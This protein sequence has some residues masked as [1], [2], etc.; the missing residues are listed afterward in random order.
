ML[1][2]HFD[3]D[4]VES[5]PATPVEDLRAETLGS[6]ATPLGSPRLR[7]L[8]ADAVARAAPA[9]ARAVVAVT[10]LT[11]ASPD[12]VLVPPLLDELN[13]GGIGDGEITV[14]VAIGLHRATS[15][16]EKR[17]K[18]GGVVDRVRVIDS[19]GRDPTKWADLGSIPPYGVPGITQKVIKD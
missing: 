9:R 7:Q 3:L 5:R 15:D 13:A 12:A 17:E 14:I 16:A 18:L 4:I 19:D 11:R 10:D 2:P 6:L 1:Q 8:A